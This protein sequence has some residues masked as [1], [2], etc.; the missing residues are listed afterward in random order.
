MCVLNL[1]FRLFFRGQNGLVLSIIFNID[2]S[3][4]KA[5]AVI[6]RDIAF[7]TNKTYC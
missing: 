6:N 5:V 1:V 3:L 4:N 7:K 2:E